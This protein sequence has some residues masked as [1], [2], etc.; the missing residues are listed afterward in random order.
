MCADSSLLC[1]L[2]ITEGSLQAPTLCF[3][4]C[5]VCNSL[6]WAGW[7]FAES[8]NIAEDCSALAQ[9]EGLAAQFPPKGSREWDPSVG[10]HLGRGRGQQWGNV[11]R[12]KLSEH[13][14][15][16]S[17]SADHVQPHALLPDSTDGQGSRKSVLGTW[18]TWSVPLPWAAKSRAWVP[19]ATCGAQGVPFP[20]AALTAQSG[21]AAPVQPILGSLSCSPPE[22]PAQSFPPPPFFLFQTN[23]RELAPK[24]SQPGVY[25]AAA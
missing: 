23:Y 25:A 10:W 5:F 3:L 14:R 4:Y 17:H 21:G 18:G 22:L 16:S 20:G 9:T 13:I 1:L 24:G 19:G 15:V 6:Q 11:A 8:R 12:R 2:G 7:V